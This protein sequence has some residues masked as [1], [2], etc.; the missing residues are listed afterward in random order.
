MLQEKIE[1]L[2]LMLEKQELED[3]I[4]DPQLYNEFF[5]AYLFLDD[6]NS[7]RFLWKRIPDLV[8][9]GNKELDQM[10]KV[11]TCLWKNEIPEFFKIIEFE[12]SKSVAEV[13]FELKERI[14]METVH[15]IGNA[16]NSIFEDKF[17]EMTNQT[18]EQI[19][20]TC[21]N[22]NW[23]VQSGP[24]PRLILPKKMPAETMKTLNAEDQLYK[25]TG[26][27]SFLEN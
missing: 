22:L 7:A 11:F 24:I 26:Y 4:K 21:K 16:Y 1:Q 19:I 2:V 23:E 17:A 9:V 20:E 12:W 18:S 5:A 15:L 8:K 14:Q 10:Y 13:M 27:V 6:L 3:S 25:L